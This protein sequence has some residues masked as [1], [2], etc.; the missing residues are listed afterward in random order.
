MEIPP[1]G[2]DPVCK[3]ALTL[4]LSR[5][6]RGPDCTRPIQRSLG[7]KT[8]AFMFLCAAMAAVA[9]ADDAAPV[10]ENPVF[11]ELTEKGL[12]MPEGTRVKLPPPILADGLDAAARGGD[13]EVRPAELHY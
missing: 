9:A 1:F 13:H 5:R 3:F 11:K 10:R 8:I 12:K 4:T 2:F 7:M 6:E